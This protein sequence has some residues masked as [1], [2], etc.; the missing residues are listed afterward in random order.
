MKPDILLADEPTSAL[1]N[2]IALE[3]MQLL[4]K[5]LD[6]FAILLITHDENLATWCSDK[7][8]RL[9]KNGTN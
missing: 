5:F 8:I 6:R 4:V 3:V 2:V 1:D 9:N 7:I